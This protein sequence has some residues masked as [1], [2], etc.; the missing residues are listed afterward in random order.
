MFDEESNDG[1]M[2]IDLSYDNS[3]EYVV[4]LRVIG[5]MCQ[6]NCGTTVR[7]ILEQIPGCVNAQ[8]TFATSYATVTINLELYGGVTSSETSQFIFNAKDAELMKNLTNKVEESVVDAVECV[9]FDASILRKGDTYELVKEEVNNSSNED[10]NKLYNDVQEFEIS[11]SENQSDFFEA[12]SDIEGVATLEVN[13]MSCA[14]CTGRVES[15]LLKLNSVKSATVSLPTSRAKVTFR[16]NESSQKYSSKD[17]DERISMLAAECA[18]AV[19]KAGYKSEV[20][21]VYTPSSQGDNGGISLTDSAARMEKAR[22]EELKIWSRLLCISLFF[23][24]PLVYMHYTSMFH[25]HSTVD[26]TVDTDP[27]WKQPISFLLAT[28]VQI[29]VG[30]RF[31]VAAYHSFP[32]MG[33]DFLICLGTSAAYIY[34]VIVLFLQMFENISDYE[35]NGMHLKPTF[36]TGAMLLSFVTLGKYLEAYARGKT[37]SAL[38][39]LMELQPVIATRCNISDSYIKK[40][41]E[42][43]V[44]SLAN[45]VNLNAIEKEDIDIKCVNKGDYLMVEP[46]GRIPTDGVIIYREGAGSCSYVDESALTGEPFPVAKKIGDNVYGS[47]VNQFSVMIVRVS[48]TG[49]NTVLARI[50]RLIEDAQVNKAP[51]QALADAV[52]AIFAPVVISIALVTLLSWLALNRDVDNQERFFIAL[53]SAIS[54]VVVACPCALGLATPTAVMVGTGVGAT[55]GL[56]IKGGA[57][58]EEAHK[59]NTVIF[60]KTGTLTTGRAILDERVEFMEN[61]K[62]TNSEKLLQNLPSSINKHNISLWLAAC[63][64]MNSEHPLAGAIVNSARS[65]FGSDYTASKEGVQVSDSMVVPG[66]GVEALVSREN[67]GQW[68]VRVGKGSFVDAA[69]DATGKHGNFVSTPMERIGDIEI[70]RLRSDGHVG[71][72][73]SVME[74]FFSSETHQRRIIGVL[75]I[76]DSIEADA[77]T[78]VSALKSMN[79]DVWMCTGDHEA[80]AKAVARSVGIEEENI[81]A[82]VTPEGKADLVTRLQKRKRSTKHRWKREISGRVA[83][84]GDGINDSIALARADVGI[85]IGAGTQVAV[86]AADIVLVRSNLHDVVV[87]LHLSRCVFNRIKVN[88]V[89]AMGYNIFALPFAAGA[90]YHWTEWRVPP[91]F[92]GFMM[93]F[94]SVTVVTSSLLLRCYSKPSISEKGS[95]LDNGFCSCMIRFVKS[96][97]K[98]PLSLLGLPKQWERVDPSP[99]LLA[100]RSED[101]EI[102]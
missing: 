88:F 3:I 1:I 28:V 8:A 97:C 70:E 99:G 72:Y 98:K 29:F 15:T 94:S 84:V 31:Y 20:I 30:K 100:Y 6:K 81:C 93:A 86:E 74:E 42:S 58:L 19:S 53:M 73:V 44:L 46:G 14:V 26:S 56:L 12:N 91:A 60:D 68:R 62:D 36:E 89:W 79:I 13:G 35:H 2:M 82:N 11:L 92:A 80:T 59:V 69:P 22:G 5:M 71:V 16:K 32:V 67:W 55:N 96:R 17:E 37:A 87:A 34:S 65:S 66:E 9:G 27:E 33:M 51:I 75:G 41:E 47:T 101:N 63:A 10:K 76:V 95:I 38:Q 64:E 39:T 23:T 90:F 24:V 57:V 54:V 43:G 40:D 45:H 85:A 4:H 77:V 83:V 102:V 7:N 78:M 48:A 52:A 25:F 21:E 18:N 50:V 49:S 61:V